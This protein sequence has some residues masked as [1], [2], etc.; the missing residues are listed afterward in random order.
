MNLFNVL[1]IIHITGGFLALGSAFV[2]VLTKTFNASH[3]WHIYSG[4]LYILGMIVIFFT[5]VPM[6]ILH[7]NLFLFLIAIFSFYLGMMG[8]RFAKNRKGIPNRVDWG[9]AAMMVP[10]TS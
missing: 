1:L 5:A 9:S 6:T 7:P 2:A 4:K 3:K 8:W 10:K